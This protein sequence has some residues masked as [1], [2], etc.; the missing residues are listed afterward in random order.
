M[1][2]IQ[3]LKAQRKLTFKNSPLT[4]RYRMCILCPHG[5]KCDDKSQEPEICPEGSYAGV[6][7][8][9]CLDCPRGYSCSEGASR[10]I[11][12]S[13]NDLKCETNVSHP[14]RELATSCSSGEY[15]DKDSTCLSCPEGYTCVGGTAA[16]VACTGFT[17]SAASAT[18]CIVS[19]LNHL[20]S[21]IK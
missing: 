19:V 17:Y 14:K 2:T 21:L 8:T 20:I 12:C 7:K 15:W 5:H 4:F 3:Q 10:P 9:E 18:A 1:V 13:K 16:P 6:G 11:R